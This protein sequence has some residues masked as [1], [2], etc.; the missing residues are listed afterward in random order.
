MR[1]FDDSCVHIWASVEIMTFEFIRIDSDLFVWKILTNILLKSA[2]I[3]HILAKINE[4]SLKK[5]L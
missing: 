1:I 5:S 3:C 4:I 2:K